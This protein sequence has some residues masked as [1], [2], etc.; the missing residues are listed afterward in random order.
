MSSNIRLTLLLC[1]A[2]PMMFFATDAFNPYDDLWSAFMQDEYEEQW[3]AVDKALDEGLPKS[4]LEMVEAIYLK[5]SKQGNQPQLIKAI[6]YRVALRAETNEEGEV[7]LVRDLEKEIAVAKEPSRSILTSILAS[8]YWNYYGDN[9]WRISQRT[10]VEDAADDDFRTWDAARFFDT[11]R[12]LFLASIREAELLQS[13]PAAS[14]TVVLVSSHDSRLYRPTLFD[15]LAHRAIDFLKNDEKNLPK[16]QRTF[17]VNNL[18]ALL[19]F[20]TFI[21]RTFTSPDAGDANYNVILLYQQLLRYHRG[22]KEVAALVDLDLQRLEFGKRITFHEDKDTTYY[23]AVQALYDAHSGSSISTLAGAALAQYHFSKNDYVTALARCDAEIARF[24]DSRGAQDCR[25]LRASILNKEAGLQVE[26]TQLPGVP[27]LISASFRNLTEMHFRIVRIPNEE[28]GQEGYRY[29][30]DLINQWLSTYIEA[31]AVQRWS[32]KLPTVS[33]YKA[34]RV[35]VAGP[36]LGMGTYIMLASPRADFSLSGNAIAYAWLRVTRLSL[37]SKEVDGDLTLWV[38]DASDGRPLKGVNAQLFTRRWDSQSGKHERQVLA[39]SVT[40]ESGRIIIT[41]GRFSDGVSVRLTQGRDTLNVERGYYTWRRGRGDRQRRTLFFTDRALYR[42]GQTVHVKGIIIDGT[43]EKAQFAVVS[44]AG[45]TVTFYDVNGQKIADT[46]VTTNEYGSFNTTFTAPA[47]VLTGMMRIANESGATQIRVEEYKRPKFEATFKPV[48]GSYALNQL[49]HAKGQATSY[50]GANVDGAEVSWRVVR[51][52]RYPYWYWWWRPMPRGAAQEI[53]HGRTTTDADGTFTVS[54]TALPDKTV[55]KKELPVFTYEISADV[56]DINGETHSASTTVSAGYTS[57]VLGIGVAS[58]L[59][60][61][62]EQDI[63]ITAENLSGSPLPAGG[64]VLVE[65]LRAPERMPRRRILPQP[66]TWLLTREEFLESF[67]RDVYGDEGNEDTWQIAERVLSRDFA[68]NAKGVD[69]LR[70]G[71]LAPGRYRISVKGKDPGGTD[72]ETKRF[73]DVYAPASKSVPYSA[74][75]LLIPVKVSCAP[76]EQARFLLS[77]AYSDVHLLYR[78]EHRGRTIEEKWLTLDREQRSFSIPVTEQHRGGL[79]AQVFFVMEYRLHSYTVPINIP[80][81]NKDLVVET[82]SFRDKLK[83]GQQEEWTL[84]VKGKEK[85][86]V[87]AE[88]LATMYDASLDAIYAQGWPAFAWPTFLYSSSID[89]ATFGVLSA[90]L[91]APDWNSSVSG[92]YQDYDRLNLFLLEYHRGLYGRGGYRMKDGMV[93]E[94]MQMAAPAMEMKMMS[95]ETALVAKKGEADDAAV[96]EEEGTEDARKPATEAMDMVKARTDFSETA[97]FFPTLSTDTQGNVVLRFTMPE[98]L[99]KWKLRVFAHT[100]DLMTGSLEKFTVTQKEVMVVPNMPR[101]LREGDRITLST[102]ITNLSETALTG[103]VSLQL[104]DALSMQPVSERFE[105]RNGTQS[106]TAEKGRSTTATW[107]VRIPEGISAVTYRVI[108]KAGDYSDG[109][110]MALPILPNRMLVTES[111]PVWVRGGTTKSFS[112]DKLRR[113]TSNTLRHHQL[114]LEM[115]SQPAW[116]AVQ[117]LPYLMEFP[118]ECSEQVF[119]RYYANSIA[120]HIANANPKIKR[121]FEQWKNTDALVSNLEKNQDLKALLLEETPWVMQGKN[122]SERKKRIALLFDLNTMADNLESAMRKLEKAQASNGGWPWFPG[123]PEDRYISQYIVAGF[124][125]LKELGVNPRDE[126]I[127]RM[128]RR[129]V[130]FID[131]RMHSDYEKLKSMPGFDPEKDHLGYLD[132]HYLYARSYFLDQK[133]DKKYDESVNFWLTQSRR[134]WPRRG[135]FMQG[136]IALGLHRRGDNKVPPAIVKSLRERSL[137]SEEMGMYWKLE[138]GWFWYQAPIETQALLIEVFDEVANDMDAVEEMK[139]WLLRQKQVQDWKTTVATAEACYALLRRGSDLLA[140]DKLVEVQ[141]GGTTIDPVAMGAKVEAG[142]GY[143]RVDWRGSDI[144]PEMGAVTL[145][146]SDQGIAWGALYWQYFEQLDR[147]TPHSTPL[148]I[149]KTLYRQNNTEKGVVLEPITESSPLRVGDVLKARITLRVDRDM[150]YVH[151]K[152]MRGSGLELID[153]LSGHRWQQ[154]LIY[155]EA[156]RDA[157]VNFFFHW[158]RKGVHVFEYPLRVSHA[159]RFS[160]GISSIQSMYAP[161]FSAHT[162]GVVVTVKPQK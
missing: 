18:D 140:S 79:V 29:R 99:T 82:A 150:E 7:I 33:D 41:A 88:I 131:A 32:V 112:F 158:L 66:D 137:R 144:K 73:V 105:L 98:A 56:T 114:S 11:T 43:D 64:T 93:N 6:A 83:P 24:P 49:V 111:L 133:P 75:S 141:L 30:Y 123:L 149:E 4:A 15:I 52:V 86:R 42:P 101:F 23:K 119:N 51:K 96:R 126:R 14:Y 151:M 135:F 20:D 57:L 72:L 34:H 59:D 121:V 116:Y 143:Y 91:H 63:A 48:E 12:A 68:T 62:V 132:V 147:I 53:A 19:P 160:N 58:Q 134:W 36:A 13:V 136:M 84:T 55:D 44:G 100:P 108:A 2:A 22:T 102:K 35:D 157:A 81:T 16:P 76:G 65:R 17:E 70:L 106:F 107:D 87:A 85:D 129:A 25:S 28:Y 3:K 46:K 21:D 118:Y 146:K 156:P 145:K 122:E 117:A 153:Q 26:D 138:S 31:D 154:G 115:T 90:R 124:G 74:G 155:Y 92:F 162:A 104:L 50:S 5:A 148:K 97:F 113:N 130:N 71:K 27:F 61:S 47:G 40:D 142:T 103:N 78:L 109:E 159:G 39:T 128:M 8:V 125:H 45:S 67:P 80:W 161:E 38:N 37:Q 110:E 89:A 60:G 1:L 95:S 77:S 127:G 10:V 120:S 152:D 9:R 54:F 139:I 69:S 94:D